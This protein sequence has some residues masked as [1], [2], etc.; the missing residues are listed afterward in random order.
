[1]EMR[2]SW[3]EISVRADEV[4]DVEADPVR[5]REIVTN[6]LTNAIQHSP[7]NAP[8]VL[9]AGME[10]RDDGMW[11]VVAVSDAGT[12]IAADHVPHIFDRFTR[13]D[14]TAGL[15]IGL[16][17]SRRLAEAHG[18]TLTLETTLGRGTTFWLALPARPLQV[19]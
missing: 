2:A 6:L 4:P 7:P 11:V 8:I 9:T 16:H 1:M 5:V 10:R 13:H 18:G 3:P 15:G 19:A 14:Q 12:G 17:L